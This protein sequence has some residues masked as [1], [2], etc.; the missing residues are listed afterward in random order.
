VEA[1]RWKLPQRTGYYSPGASGLSP[2]LATRR[3]WRTARRHMSTRVVAGLGIL[4]RVLA[5]LHRAQVQLLD[6]HDAPLLRRQLRLRRRQ[7]GAKPLHSCGCALRR[8]RRRADGAHP[9]DGEVG[10]RGMGQCLQPLGMRLRAR[11]RVRV[12]AGLRLGLRLRVGVAAGVLVGG[13]GDEH[14]AEGWG[15]SRLRGDG[16]GGRE[17]HRLQSRDQPLVRVDQ[18]RPRTIE[19]GVAIDQRH[20]PAARGFELRPPRQRLHA[21]ELVP[22]RAEGRLGT[23]PGQRGSTS[24]RAASRRVYC[25]SIAHPSTGPGPGPG[26]GPAPAPALA[27]AL[28][29]A[30]ALAWSAAD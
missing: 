6:G 5:M 13:G 3:T 18:P 27:P 10:R 15:G 8:R 20:A 26:P 1:T 9:L 12:G 14:M 2:G 28:V 29:L 19:H 23:R 24:S 21:R 7:L 16:L 22:A 30:L 25:S 11:A 17:G 4:V